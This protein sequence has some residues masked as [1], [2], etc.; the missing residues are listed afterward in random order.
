LGSFIL[1]ENCIKC[2]VTH[3]EVKHHS[4]LVEV[5]FST[6]HFAAGEKGG[7]KVFFKRK[8]KKRKKETGQSTILTLS[9]E[10]TRCLSVSVIT[11]LKLAMPFF[12]NLGVTKHMTA[13]FL[14]LGVLLEISSNYFRCK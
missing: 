11:C 8:K 4:S 10:N 2:R 7:G 6:L 1:I 5:T 3:P 9:T 14:H 12:P 13:A